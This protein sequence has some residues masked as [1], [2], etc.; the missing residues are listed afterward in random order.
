MEKGVIIR[1]LRARFDQAEVGEPVVWVLLGPWDIGQTAGARRLSRS[2]GLLRT[3][4]PQHRLFRKLVALQFE[5][6]KLRCD[7][8]HWPHSGV[9]PRAGAADSAALSHRAVQA[10]QK[11][12]VDVVLFVTLEQTLLYVL[13]GDL[14][15]NKVN[16]CK[17]LQPVRKPRCGE[18]GQH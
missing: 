9:L 5:L 12:G 15:L 3:A 18:R 16:I 14:G 13:L 1:H 10:R 2:P 11:G 4:R 7:A 8:F 6:L 17:L